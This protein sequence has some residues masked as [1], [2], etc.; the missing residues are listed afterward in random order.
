[1]H[2]QKYRDTASQ[3]EQRRVPSSRDEPSRFPLSGSVTLEPN[4][5]PDR[6]LGV[7]FE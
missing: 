1:L 3:T 7:T 5:R 4:T 2:R 6:F